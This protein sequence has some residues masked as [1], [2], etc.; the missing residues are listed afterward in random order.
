MCSL[1]FYILL[2]K[3]VVNKEQDSHNSVFKKYT[4]INKLIQIYFQSLKVH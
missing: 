3:T 2:I 4:E 1:Y